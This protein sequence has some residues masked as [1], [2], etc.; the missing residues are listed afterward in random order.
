MTMVHAAAANTRPLATTT[1]MALIITPYT[2]HN[3]APAI[4]AARSQDGRLK[5]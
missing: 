3:D 2:I 5:K 1:G 4:C